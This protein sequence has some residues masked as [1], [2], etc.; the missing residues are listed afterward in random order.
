[1][2]KEQYH[3]GDLASD[4]I[5]KGLIILVKEGYD[6]FSLRQVA[7][8]CGVSQTAPYRHFKNKDELILAIAAAAVEKFNGVLQGAVDKYPGDSQSQLKEMGCA[9]IEFFVNNPEYLHLIFLSDITKRLLGG[10]AEHAENNACIAD[11]ERTGDPFGVFL[12]TVERYHDE[13]NG[14]AENPMSP[15]ELVLYCWGLVHGISI[16]LSR[17]EFPFGDDPLALARKMIWN[18]TFPI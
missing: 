17:K 18:T 4:L 12:K 13:Y 1:L 2:S 7:K 10:Q 14:R 8:A 3:H 6:K 15:E 16:I 5:Q 9:Y 11:F